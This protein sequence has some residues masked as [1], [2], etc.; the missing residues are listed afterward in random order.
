MERYL[1]DIH[2]NAVGLNKF[3]LKYLHAPLSIASPF[4]LGTT[5]LIS[6]LVS[7]P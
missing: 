3:Y 1:K 2:F 4:E 7:F 5:G 6:N